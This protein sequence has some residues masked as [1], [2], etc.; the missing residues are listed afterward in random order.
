[1]TAKIVAV[2]NDCEKQIEEGA[3]YEMALDYIRK[4]AGSLYDG[5]V[6][7]SALKVNLEQA[8]SRAKQ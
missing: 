4:H 5:F 1:M 7:E 2:A 6:V 3:S 8:L